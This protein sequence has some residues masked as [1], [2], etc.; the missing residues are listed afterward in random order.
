MIPHAH[1]CDA[2]TF[3]CFLVVPSLSRCPNLSIPLTS[4]ILTVCPNYL[5]LAVAFLM[6]LLSPDLLVFPFTDVLSLVLSTAE[7]IKAPVLW[8][9]SFLLHIARLA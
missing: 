5:N 4:A 8:W 9:S 2:A 3:A 7:L 6:L 1:S